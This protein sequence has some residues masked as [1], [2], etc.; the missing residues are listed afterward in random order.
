MER[1]VI[2]TEE[3]WKTLEKIIQDGIR[4]A[5][6]IATMKK[7]ERKVRTPGFYTWASML[8]RCLYSW[9]I[10]YPRYGGRGIKVCDRWRKSFYNF[11]EDMGEKPVGMTL[12]RINND[13]DYEPSNCRWASHKEQTRNR[14]NT[15][16][17]THK[18]QTKTFGEW[19]E[20]AGIPRSRLEQR[21]KIYGWD[22]ER[23]LTT[24][25]DTKKN[26]K[27]ARHGR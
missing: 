16:F 19:S 22:V 10:S 17:L 8:K 18:G 3:D 9:D 2:E 15:V 7:Y 4:Q 5:V 20:V 14:R 26:S 25:I 1:L 11:I 24:P 23:A 13:G 21:I 27:G 12:D 6:K